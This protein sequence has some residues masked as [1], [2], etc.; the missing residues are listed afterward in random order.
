MLG[1]TSSNGTVVMLRNY[2]ITPTINLALACPSDKKLSVPLYYVEGVY[3][4][5]SWQS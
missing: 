2:L 1:P 5:G 3:V 4:I